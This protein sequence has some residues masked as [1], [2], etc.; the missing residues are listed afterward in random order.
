MNWRPI[1]KG[2]NRRRLAAR[3]VSFIDSAAKGKLLPIVGFGI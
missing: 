2:R 3:S 1:A